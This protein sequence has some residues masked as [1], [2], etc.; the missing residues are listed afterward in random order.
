MN[1]ANTANII[2]GYTMMYAAAQ[3]QDRKNGR[4]SYLMEVQKVAEH[5]AVA[6]KHGGFAET[7]ALAKAMQEYDLEYLGTREPARG[8]ILDSAND[9]ATGENHFRVLRDQPDTYRDA[10]APG[11]IKRDRLEGGVIPKDGM[12]NALASHVK[13]LGARHSIMLSEQ[14]RALVTARVLY[15]SEMIRRYTTLQKSVLT[16]SHSSEDNTP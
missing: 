12:Q 7:L 8:A 3:N 5:V 9:L 13:H 10:V 11:F 6:A 4:S 2:A 16:T 1:R 15:I 14:E